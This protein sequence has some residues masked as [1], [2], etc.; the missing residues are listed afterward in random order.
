M[1]TRFL[2][3]KECHIH[4]KIKEWLLELA[5]TDTM[6]IQRS[7]KNPSRVVRTEFT[8]KIAEMEEKGAT[9]EELA[10]LISGQNRQ[11]AY[12]TGDIR[13]STISAGQVVGLI[14]SIP[15][16]KEIIDN[17]IS[18]AGGIMERLNQTGIG[19]HR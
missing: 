12:V 9:L 2:A 3:S 10:P 14:H 8:Q 11:S 5:E 1:G 7:L 6:L 17:I 15:S 16:V 13:N 18:E 19:G 4:P